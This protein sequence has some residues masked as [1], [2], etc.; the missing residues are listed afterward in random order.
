MQTSTAD[1]AAAIHPRLLSHARCELRRAGADVAGDEDLVQDAWERWLRTQP[2]RV[3]QWL[4]ICIHGLAVD[5]ARRRA[6]SSRGGRPDP[7][8]MEPVS[9][10]VLGA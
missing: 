8:D 4:R 10:E 9:L 2:V 7:L 6:G 3:E 1:F 5:R